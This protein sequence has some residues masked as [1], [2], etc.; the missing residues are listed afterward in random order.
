MH[1]S[2]KVKA[3]TSLK[4]ETQKKY[5]LNIAGDLKN[6]NLL[7]YSVALH[8]PPSCICTKPEESDS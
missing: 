1:L 8:I 2:T 5:R 7:K 3:H 4:A 6:I